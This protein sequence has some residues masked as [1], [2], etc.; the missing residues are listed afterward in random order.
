MVSGGCEQ[1][2]FSILHCIH[3]PSKHAAAISLL[4]KQLNSTSLNILPLTVCSAVGILVL[5]GFSVLCVVMPVTSSLFWRTATKHNY[6][7]DKKF[8][9]MHA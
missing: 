7:I 2:W 1:A 9:I 3:P 5:Q 6:L 8:E 4:A